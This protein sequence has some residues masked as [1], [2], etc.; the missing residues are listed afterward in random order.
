MIVLELSVAK[1]DPA[2]GT[3]DDDEVVSSL[4]RNTVLVSVM[5]ANNETGVIQPVAKIAKAVRR[6][7]KEMGGRKK[8]FIHTD[9]AQVL[10]DLAFSCPP[11]PS[12]SISISLSLSLSP[13]PPLHY[14]SMT[15]QG[16][17]SLINAGFRKGPG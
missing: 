4:R 15:S 12:I 14:T 16:T 11:C 10:M 17:L 7:Q 1:V 9:A 6:W 2:N 8:I 5:L 3:V 13:S